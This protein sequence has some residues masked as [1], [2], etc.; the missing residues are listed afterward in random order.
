MKIFV[1]LWLLT[2]LLSAGAPVQAQSETQPPTFAYVSDALEIPLRAGAS[3][4]YKIIGAVR[5]GTAVEVLKVDGIKAYTQI[6]TP[7]GVKGWLPSDRLTETPGSQEQLASVRQELE[8]LKARHQDL[9]QHMDS[10]VNAPEGGEN[11]S[12]PQLYEEALRLRHRL[13][14]YRR[15][16]PDTV[17]LDE[18][19]RILQEQVVALER[20]LQLVEQENRGLRNDNHQIRMLMGAVILG[21]CLLLAVMMPRIREQR[22]AQWSRL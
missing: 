3:N 14:Q 7:T 21:V 4:R 12:Y 11:M 9:Q 5:G 18:R 10:V 8:R 19:N 2:V 17:A 20:Q 1:Q 13:A 16:A 22:R 15:V 6:R